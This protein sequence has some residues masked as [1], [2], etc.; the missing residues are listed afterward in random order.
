MRLHR[1]SLDGSTDRGWGW[2]AEGGSTDHYYNHR[3]VTDLWFDLG[4]IWYGRVDS[5]VLWCRRIS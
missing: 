5:S 3:L 4:V 1:N 2:G